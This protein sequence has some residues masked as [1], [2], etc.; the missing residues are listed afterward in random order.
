MNGRELLHAVYSGE[1]FDRLPIRGIGGWTETVERWHNEGLGPDEDP[2]VVTGLVSD[3]VVGL[4]LHLNMYPLFDIRILD[5]GDRYVTLVDEYGVTRMILRT[6]FDRS[7]GLMGASGAMSSMSH[8]I[9]FPVKDLSSWKEIYEERFNAVPEG[10]VR[11]EDEREKAEVKERTETR[12]MTHF[13]FPFGGLFSAVRQLMGLEG[14]VYAM[15]D[16]PELVHTIVSDLSDFYADAYAMLAPEIRLD[17]VT[18]FEDM[19]SNRAPLVSPAMFREFYAP[20]YRKYIGNLK[21][22]GVEHVFMDTDG[23]ARIIIPELVKC[24]FTGIHPCEIKA[25]MDPRHILEQYPHFCC[26]GGIDKIAVSKGGDAI[27]QEFERRFKTAWA[28]GRYT[29]G[30]DHAFPPDISWQNAQRYAELFLK[31][32]VS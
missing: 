16:N 25:G 28:L 5:K 13:N 14:A 21:E 2:N 15:A 24:G 3:D 8:W 23:D 26:N 19:C 12:W 4:G 27:E 31:W 17:Q 20:G 6:D 11:Y 18:C 32:C 30:L 7:G 29:P 9:D 1:K 10:R 22:M